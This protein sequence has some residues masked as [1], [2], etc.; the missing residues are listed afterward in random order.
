MTIR[1]QAEEL[2]SG[3]IPGRWEALAGL[4]RRYRG[5]DITVVYEAGYSGFWL[6]DKLVEYGVKCIVTPPSLVPVEY[7]NRVKT[8]RF[9]LTLYIAECPTYQPLPSI[10]S[11]PKSPCP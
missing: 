9:D 11:L 7:G 10:L 4:L 1:T 5:Y 3:G 6:H 2:F 8:D